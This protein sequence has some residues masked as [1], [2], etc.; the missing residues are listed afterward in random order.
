MNYLKHDGCLGLH[1]RFRADYGF[2][3]CS[4]RAS[5][6]GLEKEGG[7]LELRFCNLNSTS[8]SPVAPR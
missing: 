8:N 2:Q 6:P 5:S 1:V 4:M 3:S 7:F